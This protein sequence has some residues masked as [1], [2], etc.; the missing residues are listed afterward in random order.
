MKT[1]MQ[2]KTLMAAWKYDR[3]PYYLIGEVTGMYEDGRVTIKDYKGYAFTPVKIMPYNEEKMKALKD[4]EIKYH[5]YYYLE[6][7]P[8]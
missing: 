5:Q 1:I 2:E 3:P 8:L 4:V 6:F 7:R